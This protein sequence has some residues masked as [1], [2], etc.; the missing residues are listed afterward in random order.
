MN[1]FTFSVDLSDP[2]QVFDRIVSLILV[3]L[4]QVHQVLADLAYQSFPIF[5]HVATQEPITLYA[6]L[7]AVQGSS[8]TA[9]P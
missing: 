5:G 7:V 1:P 8:Q 3:L 9:Y 6:L 2:L 4:D